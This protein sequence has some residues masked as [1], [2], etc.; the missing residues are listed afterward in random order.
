MVDHKVGPFGYGSTL[1]SDGK[2]NDSTPRRNSQGSSSSIQGGSDLLKCKT[3]DRRVPSRQHGGDTGVL[4][5]NDRFRPLRF[6]YRVRV[7]TIITNRS[8]TLYRSKWCERVTG[9]T[10]EKYRYVHLW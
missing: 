9:V 4:D 3:C 6:L 5:D 1:S 8:I 10:D 2:G 7:T